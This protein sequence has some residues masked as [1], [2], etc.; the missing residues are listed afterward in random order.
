MNSYSG[1]TLLFNYKDISSEKIARILNEQNIA[2]RSGFH[3]SPLAHKTLNTGENGA[4]RISFS[5]F[6]SR[7]DIYM[8]KEVLEKINGIQ[9]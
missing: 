7:S 1:N 3:C 5:V 8:L 2:V 4:V 6:N 9:I